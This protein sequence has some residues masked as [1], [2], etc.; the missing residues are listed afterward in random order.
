MQQHNTDI[1]GGMS[2]ILATNRLPA[3]WAPFLSALFHRPGAAHAG[4]VRLSEPE[5]RTVATRNKK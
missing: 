3:V 4:F 5:S 1:V 2:L